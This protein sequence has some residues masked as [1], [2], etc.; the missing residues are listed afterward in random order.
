MSSADKTGLDEYGDYP[1]DI[2]NDYIEQTDIDAMNGKPPDVDIVIL[3]NTCD[4]TNH[5]S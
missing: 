1:A 2:E 5:G 4:I 3:Q